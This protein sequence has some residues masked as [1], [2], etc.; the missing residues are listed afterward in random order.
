MIMKNS[1][2]VLVAMMVI[3]IQG[4]RLQAQTTKAAAG[5]YLTMQDYK[6]GKLSYTPDNKDNMQLHS[7]LSGKHIGVNYGGKNISLA[8]NEIFG[9]RK[10]GLDFRYFH[11]EAYRILDTAGF[12]LYSREVLT[13]GSKGLK[14]VEQYFYSTDAATPILNLTI[15]NIDKSFAAQADFRYNVQNYFHGDAG[16]MAYDRSIN[17]YELK[18]LYFE[19]RHNGTPQH[20]AL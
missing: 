7:F 20:A 14:P 16:L 4:I 12:L 9:Y 5:V 11:N 15:D 2:K 6:A 17:Q 19:Y 10:D 13:P 8:K 3:G 1:I 18:H